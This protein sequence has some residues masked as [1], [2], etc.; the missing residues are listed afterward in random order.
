MSA[1]TNKILIILLL[2]AIGTNLLI[3]RD[4]LAKYAMAL[5]GNYNR[6]ATENDLFRD[7]WNRLDEDF[8]ARSGGAS[9]NMQGVL[10]MNNNQISNLPTPTDNNNAATKSYVDNKIVNTSNNSLKMICGSTVDG[11]TAWEQYKPESVRVL[12]VPTAPVGFFSSTPRYFTSL[13]GSYAYVSTGGGSLY[14]ATPTSFRF[15][16]YYIG[17]SM[18]NLTDFGTTINPTQANQWHWVINWCAVGI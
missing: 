13:S 1:H 12:T 2:L 6:T 11:A 9:S 5:T 15:Y 8:V 16:V 17:E 18:D 14:N 4:D 7:D 3:L 10:D